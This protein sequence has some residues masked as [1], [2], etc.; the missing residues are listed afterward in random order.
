MKVEKV[1][2]YLEYLP[3]SCTVPCKYD[4]YELTAIFNK[5]MVYNVVT[6]LSFNIYID[7]ITE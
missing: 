5:T 6:M 2:F 4:K 3:V 7:M 1:Y